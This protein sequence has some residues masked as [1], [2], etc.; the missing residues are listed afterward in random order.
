ML[1]LKLQYFGHLMWKT[2]SSENTLMLGKIEGRRRRGWQRMSWLDGI[3]NSMYMSLS[4]LWECVMD[5]EAWHAAV[6]GV[7]KS[8]TQLS[9]LNELNWNELTYSLLS[10]SKTIFSILSGDSLISAE[11]CGMLILIFPV[12]HFFFLLLELV[13]VVSYQRKIK[14]QGH[15]FT[16]SAAFSLELSTRHP[17]GLVGFLPCVRASPSTSYQHS[18]AIVSISHIFTINLSFPYFS[19]HSTKSFVP[20]D[21]FSTVDT[22]LCS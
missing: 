8:Q 20:M 2:D 21:I 9:E 16:L 6:R 3:T 22:L 7:V 1:K 13:L 14:F 11:G 17:S 12:S 4:K 10:P 19:F 15:Q 18:Q 5:G